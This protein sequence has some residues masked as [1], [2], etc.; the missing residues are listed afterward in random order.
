MNQQ[1]VHPKEKTYFVISLI[2][3]ILV[4]VS[5]IFTIVGILYILGILLVSFFV[6]GLMIGNIK[7]NGVKLTEK[8]FPKIYARVVELCRRMEI[9]SVPEIYIMESGGA[10]NAFASRFFGKNFVVLYSDIVELEYDNG[11]DELDFVIA[12]ELAH[13]KRK[14]ITK[15]MLIL[16]ALWTPLGNAYSRACEFTCDRMAAAYTGKP[17][18][19]VRGLT[20]LAA[21]KKLYQNVDTSA[22]LSNYEQDQGFFTWLDH[23]LSSH[24]PLPLRIKEILKLGIHQEQTPRSPVHVVSSPSMA[25]FQ[26]PWGQQ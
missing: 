21:G 9:P 5:L 7:N 20:I 10:L 23:I 19:A 1:L 3:S 24:P 25:H 13:I 14:H 12:H 6:H 2:F 16:P 17:E 4:Y 8:Q 18:N 22:Y 15:N 26:T 11:S